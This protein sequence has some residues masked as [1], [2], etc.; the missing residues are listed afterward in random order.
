MGSSRH[1]VP[2]IVGSTVICL[3]W[4]SPRVRLTP[5]STTSCLRG[6]PLILVLYVDDLFSKGSK[7]LI[8]NC[9]RDL[10][11][12]FE[13]KDLGLMHCFLDLEV[14]QKDGQIFL[15]QGKYAVEILKQLAC[16]ISGLWQHPWLLTGRR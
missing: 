6:E 15:G 9:K 1:H 11:V 12:E 3:G 2:G 5:T 10:A 14:W 7:K 8:E 16:R 13:M 4:A